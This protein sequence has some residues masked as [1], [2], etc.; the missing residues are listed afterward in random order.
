MT[1]ID[2]STSDL[3]ELIAPV[4]PHASTDKDLP[5]ITVVRLE[6]ADDTLYAVATDKYTLAATRHPIGDDADPVKIAISRSDAQNLLRTFKHN[7]K[8]DPQLQLVIDQMHVH[9]DN[10]TVLGLSLRV[11]SEDGT[12][13]TVQDR[14]VSALDWRT[15]LGRVLH[16][17]LNPAAPTVLM[18]PAYFPRW[19]KA[20][21]KWERLAVFV[22]AS[23]SD[24]V[25]VV[26]DQHF[27]GVWMPVT[28]TEGEP[29]QVLDGNPW[30]DELA[31]AGNG[32]EWLLRPSYTRPSEEEIDTDLLVQAAE[33]VVS[34][35]FGSPSMLRRKLKISLVLAGRLMDFLHEHG[36]VG[37]AEGTKARDVL[38][39]ADRIDVVVASLRAGE[40]LTGAES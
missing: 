15:H 34:T 11:A 18:T 36:V 35:Q 16:R 8:S 14:G 7:Q 38:V 24:P 6:V 31:A 13:L 26:G 12:K 37:P 9:S 27:V 2:L 1:R 39:T 22:G 17:P 40:V 30:M 23:P 19:I 21:A 32:P 28:H 5:E 4:L 10:Q 33:L 20:A 25:L 29:Q 3:H